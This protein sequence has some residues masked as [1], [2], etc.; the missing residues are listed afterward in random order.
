MQRREIER[1]DGGRP[2]VE[3]FGV[4]LPDGAALVGWV[5]FAI[6][7]YVALILGSTG[8][9][10]AALASCVRSTGRTSLLLFCMAFARPAFETSDPRSLKAW[11]ARNERALLVSVAAS[12]TIHAAALIWLQRITGMQ[13]DTTT[14]VVG[15]VGYAMIYLLA[16]G[17][18]G[19][20]DSGSRA[21]ASYYVWAVFTLTTASSIASKPLAVPFFLVCVAAL[22]VRARAV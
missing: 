6:L 9:G 20:T 8:V 22:Y 17:A 16:L 3:L 2:S 12:H 21:A 14:L 4:P 11:A 5:T 15:G 1:N 18:A 13:F 19:G 10:E 7:I